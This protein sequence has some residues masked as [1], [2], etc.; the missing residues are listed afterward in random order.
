MHGTVNPAII[1][2]VEI[3][4]KPVLSIG[5]NVSAILD[6]DHATFG[7]TVGG[8]KRLFHAIHK[9]AIEG[10]ANRIARSGQDP[11]Q[12]GRGEAGTLRV[13]P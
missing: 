4:I 13:V 1:R 7:I 3:C 9:Y 5:Q 12:K 2:E 11:L 10:N 8:W 6:R